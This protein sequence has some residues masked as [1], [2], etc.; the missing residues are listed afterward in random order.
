MSL[1]F[2]VFRKRLNI[3]QLT[4]SSRCSSFALDSPSN[5]SLQ[6][7]KNYDLRFRHLSISGFAMQATDY[8][9]LH[10]EIDEM[11]ERCGTAINVH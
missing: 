7:A 9:T 5:V 4:I 2:D 1:N 11:L 3:S 6:K 10:V 8:G